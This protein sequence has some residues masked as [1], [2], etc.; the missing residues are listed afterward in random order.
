MPFHTHPNRELC[1][2]I[3]KDK[4]EPWLI[5]T[6][7]SE[8]ENSSPPCPIQRGYVT[9]STDFKLHKESLN[10]SQPRCVRQSTELV[11]MTKTKTYPIPTTLNKKRTAVNTHTST[12]LCK[13]KH[14]IGGHYKKKDRAY[15]KYSEQEKTAH[16]NYFS[17][18]ESVHIT[19]GNTESHPNLVAWPKVKDPFTRQKEKPNPSPPCPIQRVYVTEST[20]F[21]LNKESL[22]S[23]QA[24]S[25]RQSTQ[26]VD[27][28]KRKPDTISIALN[29]KRTAVNIQNCE[30][31]STSLCM[32]RYWIGGHDKTKDPPFPNYI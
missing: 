5:P 12:S 27:V 30:L 28:T 20:D 31:V 15:P 8:R 9:G 11:D 21:I 18:S 10:S 24:R 2:D 29:K 7:N 19:K 3:E 26:L 1:I 23:S 17:R 32:I 4:T 13:R 16:P 22:N 6:E 14:S 25:V